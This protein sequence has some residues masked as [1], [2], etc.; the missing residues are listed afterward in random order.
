M[1]I[2]GWMQ[3]A[4]ILSGQ[5]L[6]AISRHVCNDFIARSAE[7]VVAASDVHDSDIIVAQWP[8]PDARGLVVYMRI[9][10]QASSPYSKP[11]RIS[12]SKPRLQPD[13]RTPNGLA[14]DTRATRSGDG[15]N[16]SGAAGRFQTTVG[17]SV[18]RK[19]AEH[20]QTIFRFAHLGFRGGEIPTRPGGEIQPSLLI[21]TPL[22]LRTTVC[23]LCRHSFTTILQSFQLTLAFSR[24]DV[25][26]YTLPAHLDGLKIT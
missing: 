15:L 6:V 3:N 4:E 24:V 18:W 5:S 21:T 22:D 8:E 19:S 23:M 26:H 16:E 13:D 14:N 11:F 12:A 17:K 1:S 10:R 20:R 7:H 25:C 2:S 9:E